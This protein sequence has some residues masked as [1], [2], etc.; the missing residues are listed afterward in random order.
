VPT[1]HPT[2]GLG[3][4]KHGLVTNRTIALKTLRNTVMLTSQGHTGIA[5][6]T[7]PIIYPK[8]LTRSTNIAKWTMVYCLVERIIVKVAN[9]ARISAEGLS[10]RFTLGIYAFVRRRLKCIA[11]HAQNFFDFVSIQWRVLVLCCHFTTLLAAKTTC[12]ELS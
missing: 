5:P 11:S 12:V 2:Q 8:T 9:L 1:L 4:L 3:T 10:P 6:H 7:M